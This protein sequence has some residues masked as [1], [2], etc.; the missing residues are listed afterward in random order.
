[1]PITPATL[2]PYEMPIEHSMP[3]PGTYTIVINERQRKRVAAALGD[4]VLAA[5]DPETDDCQMDMVLADMFS[6][7]ELAPSPCVNGFVL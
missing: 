2:K 7:P 1:M 5:D 3:D 4:A 6:D